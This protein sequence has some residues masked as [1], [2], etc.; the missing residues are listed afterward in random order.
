M[1]DTDPEYIQPTGANIRKGL[2]KIID[3][4]SSGD[5]L[6]VH[7]SGHGTQLPAET[8]DQDDTGYDECIVPT[9]MNLITD[10]EFRNFV[11]KVPDGVHFTLVCDSC[12]SGGLIENEKEQIGE[13]TLKYAAE[14]APATRAFVA[15]SQA[16]YAGATPAASF[17]TGAAPPDSFGSREFEFTPRHSH[18]KRRTMAKLDKSLPIDV[19]TSILASKTGQQVA[20]GTIRTSLYSVFGKDSSPAVQ[21]FVGVLIASAPAILAA[22]AEQSGGKPPPRPPSA[23]APR[24]PENEGFFSSIFGF[25]SGQAESG[26]HPPEVAKAKENLTKEDVYAG[27]AQRRPATRPD[28]GIL[29]SGCEPE[30]TSAD[31]NP[32]NNPAQA[33][34][35]LSNAIVTYLDSTHGN[36]TNHQLVTAVRAMLEKEG[37]TQHPC[38]YCSDANTNKPFICN[39]A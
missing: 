13:T 7:Y 26:S 39:R 17:Y 9:D 5:V 35:A 11:D 20:V 24:P 1:V 18:H 19:L 33:Y 15:G 27:A 37:F 14:P 8:G 36:V 28:M 31:A 25:L 16:F 12:H 30:E 23:A 29:V 10:D 6:F 4:S 34:G 22:I 32:C 38:L 3:N 2:T 21:A